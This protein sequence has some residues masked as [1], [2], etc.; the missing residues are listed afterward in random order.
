MIHLLV[1]NS[2]VVIAIA[3]KYD[4][5]ILLHLAM[6]DGG[7]P[8]AAAIAVSVMPVVAKISAISSG[9]ARR[10]IPQRL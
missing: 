5:P 3:V 9:V 6:V 8:S 7:T 4:T 10:F 2:S 1:L